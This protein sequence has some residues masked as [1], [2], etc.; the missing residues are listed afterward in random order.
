MTPSVNDLSH[1]LGNIYSYTSGTA[2]GLQMWTAQSGYTLTEI[3]GCS[4]KQIPLIQ[5]SVV[6]FLLFDIVSNRLF[7]SS[8]RKD[9]LATRPKMLTTIIQ[10][11]TQTCS[12]TIDSAFAFDISY[13]LGYWVFGRNID[14]HVDMIGQQNVLLQSGTASVPPTF[15]TRELCVCEVD[16]RC[17][18]AVF[19]DEYYMIFAFPRCMG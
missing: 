12:G 14:Q 10:F 9:I 19:R 5:L 4:V 3:L 13:H 11:V 18:F 6:F 16:H 2:G 1:P 7:I 17:L 8:Y 15:S